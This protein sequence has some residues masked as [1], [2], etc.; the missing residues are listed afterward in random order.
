MSILSLLI[1]A[2]L[3]LTDPTGDA[4]GD[5]E[6]IAPT[7]P[8]YAN[9]AIFDIHELRVER[10]DGEGPLRPAEVRLTLA[11]VRLDPAMASGFAGAIFDIY[12]DTGEGGIES[13]LPG[14]GMLMPPNS[15]WEYALRLG[16]DAAFAVTH[17]LLVPEPDEE[18][19]AAP[20]PAGVRLPDGRALARIPVTVVIDGNTL[21]V[22]LPWN[23]PAQ[24]YAYAVS[25]VHDSFSASGW[26]QLAQAPS[27]W[28][29]SG[30]S[31]SVPVIDLVANSQAEQV[32]ALQEGVLPRVGGTTARGWPWLLLMGSGVGLAFYG[33]WQRRRSPAPPVVEKKLR[34]GLPPLPVPPVPAPALPAPAI[35]AVEVAA[36][37]GLS[38]VSV[39]LVEQTVD[40]EEA[41]V[42][43]VER[44]VGAADP[45]ERPAD[46]LD[47]VERPIRP[48][49]SGTP[50]LGRSLAADPFERLVLDSEEDARSPVAN[51]LDT[52]DHSQMWGRK[53]A[54]P[55]ILKVETAEPTSDAEPTAEGSAAPEEEA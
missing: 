17:D 27:P 12:I 3:T 49:P 32:R 48:S 31:Q 47:S 10:L 21:R 13:T 45:V 19:S 2:A 1:L 26:R 41:P 42:D 37:P 33:L 44:S 53:R 52:V 14:P 7:S 51:D 18:E 15:G 43:S 23:L 55:S 8:I 50:T 40:A 54:E 46:L 38:E 24:F 29:F 16:P 5:G 9:P 30:G 39:E 36:V 22:S 34:T 28:A 6:L 20:V 4:F 35:V 11:G 25:G